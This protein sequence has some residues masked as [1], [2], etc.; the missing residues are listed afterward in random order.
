MVTPAGGP[1]TDSRGRRGSRCPQRARRLR[2]TI[3]DQFRGVGREARDRGGHPLH[4]P[5]QKP[6]FSGFRR[7]LL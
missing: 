2:Y 6:C 3:W 7:R 1:G 4:W 5:P